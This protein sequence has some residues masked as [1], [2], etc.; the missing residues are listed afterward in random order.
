MKLTT[1]YSFVLGMSHTTIA[2]SSQNINAI[3]TEDSLDNLRI[4]RS[5]W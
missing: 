4:S 5:F 2:T 1:A 3:G